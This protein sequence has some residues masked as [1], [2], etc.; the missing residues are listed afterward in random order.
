MYAVR[1]MQKSDIK[2]IL[3]VQS[4]CYLSAKLESEA[5]LKARL[6]VSPD[7]AWVAV[8]R[9][10]VCAYLV[11]YR[12]HWGKVTPLD[13]VFQVPQIPNCLYLHDL[14]VGC[15]AIRQG[16][17]ERLVSCATE[18]ALDEGLAFSSLVSV[19]GSRKFWERMG[20]CV[21]ED[22]STEATRDLATY[23]S[24]ALYMS[25]TLL[26]NSSFAHQ[27]PYHPSTLILN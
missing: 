17:G 13:K 2:E 19:Q 24:A 4:E 21:V 12:S 26:S 3:R 5:I 7:S 20:Y 25:R 15:R 10:G 11:A 16:L 14:A 9:E 27:H 6:R 1:L 18:L 22:L 23:G 8:D